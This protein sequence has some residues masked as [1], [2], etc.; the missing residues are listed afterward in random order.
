MSAPVSAPV[1]IVALPTAHRFA[2]GDDLATHLLA[3]L[4]DA[5]VEL[6][7]HDVVCV[8][9]K[10]VSLAEGALVALP[11]DDPAARRRLAADIATT[12]VA[13]SPQVLVTRT[14]HGFVA[15]N[16][17]IDTSNVP[18]G[19]ALLLPD[20]PD[21]SADRLRRDLRTRTGA[22][23]GV[24]ITDTFGRPW[25][26]G[27]TEV[28]L[29]VAGTVALRDERGTADLD[30]RQLAVT[31]AAVADEIAGAA[32]LVRAKASGT[33]FVVVRGLPPSTGPHGSGQDLVRPAEE[34]LFPAG[35]PT[36]SERAVAIRRTVRSFDPDRPVP[37][38]ALRA[39]IAAAA[40]SPAP[41]HTRP[42]R[43]V[44]V[45]TTTRTRLLDAMAARWA[46]DLRA[47]GV[48]PE[49]IARRQ[50]RSDEVL[51]HAPELLAPFVVLDGADD[52]PDA[53]RATA[54]RDLFL[55]SGGAALQSLQVVL[56]GHGLGAAWLSAS[57][58]CPD[59]VR[60]VLRLEPTW[61]PIGLVAVGWPASP[62]AP[63]RT[64]DL[65]EVLIER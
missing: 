38:D 15:A 24:V 58:F 54:E 30:D 22:D 49:I 29:G 13:A 28:A 55:L 57:A 19:H 6:R 12:V 65:D 50:R 53:R 47:D 26:V 39:A 61:Q 23:V 18:A 31:Q 34:D 9:S 36:A 43:I 40:R 37:T 14:R 48:A 62:A 16:G 64:I 2:A 1:T 59:T 7:D 20:D 44:R 60:E 46:E 56:A 52:Y 63:P 4:D 5:R 51:R 33:P 35:G 41:H 45:R 27:Q 11:G 8:A 3:A 32:D 10:V 17:G 21:A 42:W 25:R